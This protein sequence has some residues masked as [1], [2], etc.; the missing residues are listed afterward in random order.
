MT[1][2]FKAEL[3]SLGK[4]EKDFSFESNM[5][6]EDNVNEYETIITPH[7]W[8]FQKKL[9]NLFYR[10]HYLSDNDV[11]SRQGKVSEIG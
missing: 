9:R 10:H 7:T 5:C 8:G 1:A 3:D 2:R 4:E 11:V 6:D